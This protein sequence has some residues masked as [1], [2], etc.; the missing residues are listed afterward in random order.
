MNLGNTSVILGISFE[1][2]RKY[3][4]SR[5]VNS[6]A[7]EKEFSAKSSPVS[8]VSDRRWN[9]AGKLVKFF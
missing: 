6:A 3:K 5:K 9:V 7:S 8:T 1:N 4:N 2:S